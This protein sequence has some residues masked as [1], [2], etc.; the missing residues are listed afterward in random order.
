MRGVVV[1]LQ[2]LHTNLGVQQNIAAIIERLGEEESIRDVFVEGDWKELDCGEMK[3]YPDASAKQ[4][5]FNLL[6]ELGETPATLYAACMRPDL[7]FSLHGVDDEQLYMANIRAAADLANVRDRAASAIAEMK[8]V[9]RCYC[10]PLLSRDFLDFMDI[11][12][13]RDAGWDGPCRL[14]PSS[15]LVRCAE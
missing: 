5:A 12:R 4:E 1:C 3:G 13:A 6:L 7:N 9:L 10:E 2:N 15:P 14:R 11:I 8:Q